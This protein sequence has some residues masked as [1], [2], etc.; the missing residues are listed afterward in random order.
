MFQYLFLRKNKNVCAG[1]IQLSVHV[2]YTSSFSLAVQTAPSPAMDDQVMLQT[3][4]DSP[5][6]LA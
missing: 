1:A 6:V 3:L 2:E 4:C 5:V